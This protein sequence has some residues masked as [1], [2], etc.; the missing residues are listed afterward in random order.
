MIFAAILNKNFYIA[1]DSFNKEKDE[2]IRLNNWLRKQHSNKLSANFSS[3]TEAQQPGYNNFNNISSL[4]FELLI[5]T[6]YIILEQTAR[7]AEQQLN[8]TSSKKLED[9]I[10]AAPNAIGH[11][12]RQPNS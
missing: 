12:Q 11:G 6:C 10:T 3:N 9:T 2:L 4:K 5:I 7:Q 1:V 8:A